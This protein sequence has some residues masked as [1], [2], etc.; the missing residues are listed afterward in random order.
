MVSLAAA[1]EMAGDAQP[2]SDQFGHRRK[3]ARA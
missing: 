2:C 1:D 3:L